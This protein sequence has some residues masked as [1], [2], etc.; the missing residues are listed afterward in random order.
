MAVDF[1]KKAFLYKTTNL[2]NGKT[3]IGVRTYSNTGQDKTYIGSGIL[4]L[5]AIKKYGKEAFKRETLL[6]AS[7]EYCYN[8]ESQLVDDEWVASRDN[9]NIATGGWGGN[10]GEVANSKHSET[11][12]KAYSEWSDE[13][14]AERVEFLRKIRDVS[15]VPKGRENINWL[16][17]WITPEGTFETCR[18]AAKA[19]SIDHRT[20]RSR[21][22]DNNNKLITRYRVNVIPLSWV[23]KT[24]SELGWNFI[25]KEVSGV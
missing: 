6:I 12:K 7:A 25:P 18:D 15:K 9:Y 13:D 11:K 24:F 23:G 20:L 16:G 1:N 2:V 4:M 19:N 21:C 10:R 5:A 3:Y 14:K 17:Y 8:I 22:R